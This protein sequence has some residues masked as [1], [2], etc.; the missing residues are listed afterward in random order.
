M[1]TPIE[2]KS[3]GRS[4]TTTSYAILAVLALRPHA[5]YELAKQ[6]GLSLR[7]IWPRADSNLYAEPKRLVEAGLAEAREEWNGSRKRT[8]YSITDA[9]HAVLR[10]WVASPSGEPRFESEALLKVFFGENGDPAELIANIDALQASARVAVE[11][12][13][14]IADTYEQGEGQ[15]PQRFALSSV[16]ARLLLEQQLLLERW[17]IWAKEI[18]ATWETTVQPE[19]TEWGVGTIRAAGESFRPPPAA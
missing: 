3:Q 6:T 13:L 14:E 12:F 19:P 11:H 1:N 17:A 9:G 8:V 2:S 5:T 16:V 7:Y 18:V 10:D 15:Y 4:L